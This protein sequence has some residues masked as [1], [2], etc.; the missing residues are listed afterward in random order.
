MKKLFLLMLL[1]PGLSVAQNVVKELKFNEENHDFGVIKE[2]DGAAEFKFEFTNQSS[3]PI[4]ITNVRASCGCT[5]PA[6]TREP[7]LPGGSGF[8]TAAYNPMNR[9]GPFNKTLTVTTSGANKTIVLRIQGKVE[10]KPRTIEDDYRGVIGDLRSEYRTINVGKVFDNKPASKV[11]K[12]Y[13]QGEK[14]LVFQDAIEAPDYIKV[15]FEP[16]TLQPKEKGTIIL[17]YDSRSNKEL[18]FVSSQITV[19][20]NEAEPLNKKVFTVYAD[21]NE[22]FEPLTPETAAVA[23]RLTI[24]TRVH[25][26]GKLTQG[27]NVSA[28]FSFK[29]SGK[30]PL[31]IRK[32]S[33]NCTCVVTELPKDEIAPNET[34]EL[35]VDF[36]TSGRR[37][38]QQKSITIYSNDPVT[39]VQRIVV[40][41]SIQLPTN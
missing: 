6:W 27:E 26:F 38:T 33:S 23:P 14:A 30:N 41:A 40:K 16:K 12:V 17:D 1:L 24:E 10:P 29:N 19:Y 21:Q 11:F 9:P 5:T 36:N 37:G 18:G 13:N 22:Y 31:N 28:V 32:V 7:V 3:E 39:P 4:T 35:K 25:D 2:L 15:R 8:I 34:I 20:T